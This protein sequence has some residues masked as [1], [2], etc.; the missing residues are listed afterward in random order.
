MFVAFLTVL[1]RTEQWSKFTWLRDMFRVSDGICCSAS[2]PAAAMILSLVC[3]YWHPNG[4]DGIAGACGLSLLTSRTPRLARSEVA[5]A[6]VFLCGHVYLCLRARNGCK[7]TRRDMIV[8]CFLAG[9]N[10]FL[11]HLVIAVVFS[12]IVYLTYFWHH[13]KKLQ[14]CPCLSCF[15]VF[16]LTCVFLGWYAKLCSFFL[17]P[18]AQIV[19]NVEMLKCSVSSQS[20]ALPF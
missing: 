20:R 8:C 13:L 19:W 14:F 15:K 7:M 17:S 11:F 18:W 3:R 9:N 12:L 2:S 16:C 6:A 4:L 1:A 5:S 10:V